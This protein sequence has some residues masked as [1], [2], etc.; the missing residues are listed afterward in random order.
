MLCVLTIFNRSVGMLLFVFI[1]PILAAHFKNYNIKGIIKAFDLYPLF[2]IELVHIFFQVNALFGNYTY[3]RFAVYLQY[4]FNLS[5]LIPIIYRK[6]YYPAIIGSG[7]VIVGSFCNKLVIALNNGKMPVFATFS[8]LTGLYKEGIL[9]QGIDGLHIQ[10]T[11]DSSLPFLGDYID[12]GFCI[13][14]F[15]DILIH[16]YIAIIVYYTIKSVNI[17]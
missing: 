3:V 4:A 14:S 11:S 17:T 9:L 10:M 6:L 7:F 2:I 13:M 12:L 5:L 16:S 8:K 15:G 1:I